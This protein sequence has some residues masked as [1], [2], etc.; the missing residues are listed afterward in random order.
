ML[1]KF[2]KF[3]IEKLTLFIGGT[4][5]IDGTSDGTADGYDAGY[6]IGFDDGYD[7][8]TMGG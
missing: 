2:R 6:D 7:A 3:E 4:G 8:A 5:D 1:E